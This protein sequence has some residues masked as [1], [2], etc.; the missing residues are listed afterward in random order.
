MD[1]VQQI[2]AQDARKL[3]S[4]P[5][6]PRLIDVREQREWAL[7]RVEGAELLPL[8]QWPGIAGESL[9]DPEEALVLI[10][11]HGVR[12]ASAASH[13]I[14]LGFKRVFNLRGGIDAWT[15]EVDPSVPLY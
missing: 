12:S 3:L 2:S 7:A 8:S 9:K 10:C 4:G 15:R 5:L 1:A 13:L 14:T 11:H 6:P